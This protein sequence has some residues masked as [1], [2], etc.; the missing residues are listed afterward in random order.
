[1]HHCFTDLLTKCN[2]MY[3]ARNPKD[4]LVSYYYHHKLRITISLMLVMFFVAQLFVQDPYMAH[5]REAVTM[6][7]NHNRKFLWY[8]DKK[9]DLSAAIRDFGRIRGI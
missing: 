6:M 5:V 7:G 9:R 8:E 3:V 2:L 1:M 4:V